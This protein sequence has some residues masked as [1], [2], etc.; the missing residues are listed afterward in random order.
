MTSSHESD[1][2]S[3][4]YPLLASVTPNSQG[5]T[6][7][8]TA[9]HL[10]CWLLC[11]LVTVI[12]SDEGKCRNQTVWGWGLSPDPPKT[13]QSASYRQAVSSWITRWLLR[14]PRQRSCCYA[15]TSPINHW[16]QVIRILNMLYISASHVVNKQHI[17]NFFSRVVTG[18][19]V[20]IQQSA[21]TM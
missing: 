18:L 16:S 1:L 5:Q 15:A 20:T 10:V 19:K 4:C 14:Q 17:S 13:A 21:A 11:L 8:S 6:M 9:D 2:S 3:C 12:H 7:L